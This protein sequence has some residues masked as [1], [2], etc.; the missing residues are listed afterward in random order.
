MKNQTSAAILPKP[1]SFLC[2]LPTA[3]L[4]MLS[5]SLCTYGF[6]S[7]P[8]LALASASIEVFWGRA[9]AHP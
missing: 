4:G 8:P 6:S 5:H 7:K 3:Q 1:A 9:M 2:A